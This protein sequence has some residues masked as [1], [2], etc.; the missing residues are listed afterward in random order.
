MISQREGFVKNFFKFF[1]KI[2]FQNPAHRDSFNII[3]RPKRKVK[4][5]SKKISKNFA[6]PRK[7]AFFRHFHPEYF[8]KKAEF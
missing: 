1:Q 7:S 2:F 6:A 3:P 4:H 5:F 8:L